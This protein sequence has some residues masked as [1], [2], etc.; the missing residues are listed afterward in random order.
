MYKKSRAHNRVNVQQM[1]A[2]IIILCMLIITTEDVNDVSVSLMHHFFFFYIRG[3]KNIR[4][5]LKQN[6]TNYNNLDRAKQKIPDEN[7]GSGGGDLD[8]SVSSKTNRDTQSIRQEGRRPYLFCG[9]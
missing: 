5:R 7:K 8:W 1:I 9:Q 4:G 2:W 3:N 6:K